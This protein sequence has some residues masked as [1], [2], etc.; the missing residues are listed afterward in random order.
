M[1]QLWHSN[2]KCTLPKCSTKS[3]KLGFLHLFSSLSSPKLLTFMLLCF[4]RYFHVTNEMIGKCDM[5]L[6]CVG[7]MSAPIVMRDFLPKKDYNVGQMRD[8]MFSGKCT[9]YIVCSRTISK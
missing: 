4:R 8:K 9:P 5:L 3:T 7:K 2:M 1:S 6:Y